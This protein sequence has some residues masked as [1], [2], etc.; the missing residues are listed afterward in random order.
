[1]SKALAL[2]IATL[3]LKELLGDKAPEV[4]LQKF[5]RD[6]KV[7]PDEVVLNDDLFENSPAASALR[8]ASQTL[9]SYLNE[10]GDELPRKEITVLEKFS[11]DFNDL[12]WAR[13]WVNAETRKAYS[14]LGVRILD[15]KAVLVGFNRA[16]K[17]A[18]KEKIRELL[19][20]LEDKLA[21]AAPEEQAKLIKEAMDGVGLKVTVFGIGASGPFSSE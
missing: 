8:M 12:F 21:A 1:M 4:D 18:I 13:F 2:N 6:Q 15:D 14:T 10:H 5:G 9:K 11:E 3:F 19:V 17:E 16:G 7:D 20:G